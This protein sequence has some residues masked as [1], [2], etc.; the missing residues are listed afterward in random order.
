MMRILF[1]IITASVLGLASHVATLLFAPGMALERSIASAVD[2]ERNQFFVLSPAAQARLLPDYP[3]DTVFGMCRFDLSRGPVKLTANL[4]DSLW[5][6]AVYSSNGK[7]LY[8]VNDRQSGANNFELKLVKAQS[9]LDL[10][11]S[12]ADDDTDTIADQAWIVSS[13]DKRGVALFWVPMPDSAQ[14]AQLVSVLAKSS[15]RSS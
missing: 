13:P 5:V 8:T 3:R 6:L 15:C 10:L 9:L 2:G 14:R 11:T 1:W 12:R 7:T 4:P